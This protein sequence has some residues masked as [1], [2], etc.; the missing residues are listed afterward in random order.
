MNIMLETGFLTNSTADQK[1]RFETAFGNLVSM[2]GI[3]TSGIW[4][5]RMSQLSVFWGETDAN[6]AYIRK[7][8][9]NATATKKAADAWLTA[10]GLAPTAR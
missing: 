5:R 8:Y 9:G 6:G 3:R 10:R 1:Y 2:S 7:D 4:A